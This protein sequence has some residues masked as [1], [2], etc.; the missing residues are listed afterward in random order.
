MRFITPLRFPVE[1]TGQAVLNDSHLSIVLEE[2][3]GEES[4]AFF[5]PEL[6]CPKS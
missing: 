1:G 5:T 6:L 4:S 2:F 3:G